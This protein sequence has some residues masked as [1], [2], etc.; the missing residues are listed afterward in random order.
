MHR[1]CY[2]PTVKLWNPKMMLSIHPTHH[3]P[4]F[5]QQRQRAEIGAAPVTVTNPIA[6]QFN[7]VNAYIT[8]KELAMYRHP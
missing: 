8:C 1:R 6:K 2:E 3:Q 5:S 7:F 4:S